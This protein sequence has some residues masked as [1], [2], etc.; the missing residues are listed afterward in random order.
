MNLG[1]IW[2]S[3]LRKTFL[4]LMDFAKT[5]TSLMENSAGC[6]F[7]VSS[8]TRDGW[9]HPKT[10]GLS[11]SN[12]NHQRADPCLKKINQEKLFIIC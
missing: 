12:Q 2:V 5:Q 3:D 9:I 4:D 10:K 7:F 8:V 1:V 6:N 11:Q